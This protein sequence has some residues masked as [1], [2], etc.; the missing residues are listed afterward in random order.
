LA[1]RE[2][3]KKG[4]AVIGS[5][6]IEAQASVVFQEQAKTAVLGNQ[7]LADVQGF[8]EVQLIGLLGRGHDISQP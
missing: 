8:A 7:A 4:P 3:A 2:L 1:R 5:I 6:A